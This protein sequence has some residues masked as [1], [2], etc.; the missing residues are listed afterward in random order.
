MS[1]TPFLMNINKII[2]S[3]ETL[4]ML[5][6]CDLSFP[7]NIDYLVEVLDSIGNIKH[8]YIK[9]YYETPNIRYLVNNKDFGRTLPNNFDEIQVKAI[10]QTALEII[11]KKF[12]IDSTRLK[13][14]DNEYGWSIEKEKG[15]APTMTQL[16]YKCT[17]KDEQGKTCTE[18]FAEKAKLEEHLEHGVKYGYGHS[19]P[20]CYL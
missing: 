4:I 18:F 9:D 11:N 15:K 13:I 3:L 10:F 1:L 6:G 14:V 7:M 2:P 19:F 20:H 17:A 16:C 8:L 12:S 5:T